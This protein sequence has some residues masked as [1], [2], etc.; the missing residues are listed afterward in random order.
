MR[1]HAV[2]V[3]PYSGA[4]DF[5]PA[6]RSRGVSPVAVLST[7]DPL[8]VFAA[9][10]HP[11]N[12][13][14][15]HC[16]RGDLDQLLATLT[17][18]EP[19]CVVPGNESGVELAERLGRVLTPA[20]GN[21][22]ELTAA[23]RDKWQMALAVQ[24]AGLPGLRQT[25]SASGDTVAA[26]LR[27]NGLENSRLVLKPPKSGGTDGTH[28]T[29]PGE[30][31]RPCFDRINGAVNRFSERNVGVLVQEFAEGSEFVVD[32]YSVGGR[33][34]LTEVCRYRK[35]VS[36]NRL[37]LYDRTDFVPPDAA[38]VPQ[39]AAYA[40]QVAD[41][42]GIRNGS[43]HAEVMLTEDGPRLIE[44]AARLGGTPLQQASRLATGDSQIDR[45]VRHVL[46]GEF[47]PGYELRQHASIVCLSA[48][49]AGVL[50][51]AE[52]LEPLRSLPSAHLFSLPHQTGETVPATEDLFTLLGW[53]LLVSPSASALDRDYHLIKEIERQI[54]I[55]PSRR[56]S[57]RL[58]SIGPQGLSHRAGRQAFRA[59]RRAA[60]RRAE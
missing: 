14:V 34:G 59:L 55:E 51:N 8:E 17:P 25:W 28:V 20:A 50:S 58:S 36:G 22:P 13:D 39:V 60:A 56:R 35:R 38:E 23:R 43:A 27:D 26:W 37:G 49:R 21:V 42:V 47:T 1:R 52:V 6:F 3:D 9:S 10:W 44:I 54:M 40:A 12:F 16:Y 29:G 41:A 2:V 11:A 33:H 53:A 7:P 4:A 57:P 48:P 30:D 19:L 46:D 15:V 18:Y 24:R 5:G 32:T 31:W 45:T